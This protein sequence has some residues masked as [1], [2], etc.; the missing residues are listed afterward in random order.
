MYKPTKYEEL[1]VDIPIY[2]ISDFSKK[3]GLS[4]KNFK[5]HNPWLLENHLNNK[6]KKVYTILIPKE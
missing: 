2:N 1:K 4:Y 5:I 6:S 3:L